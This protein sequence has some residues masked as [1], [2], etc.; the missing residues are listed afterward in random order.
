[1]AEVGTNEAYAKLEPSYLHRNFPTVYTAAVT[2]FLI[3]FA[4]GVP[5]SAL[6]DVL[7]YKVGAPTLL[8]F[9]AQLAVLGMGKAIAD[10]VGGYFADKW[11]NGRRNVMIV[12]TLLVVI[13]SFLIW[14]SF[15][16]LNQSAVD[17]IGAAV[18]KKKQAIPA[19][20]LLPF[21]MIVGGQFLNGFGIGM[22]NGAAMILLQ[23]YGGATKRGL[24]ASLQKFSLYSGKTTATYLGALLGVVT[25]KV[26]FPFLFVGI[27]AV[28]AMILN[29]VM[30]KDS[31]EHILIPAGV[32]RKEPTLADYKPAFTNRSLYSVYFVAFMGKW[33]DSWFQ[34][35]SLLFM[36][37]VLSVY[38]KPEVGAIAAAFGVL[39]SVLNAYSGWFSDFVGRRRIALVGTAMGIVTPLLFLWFLKGPKNVALGIALAAVWG[40]GTGLYYGITEV[41]PGDVAR[42]ASRGAIIGTF[43]FFRDTG[44]VLVP[45]IF[46]VIT[47]PRTVGFSKNFW[48]GNERGRYELT[49]WATSLM[50]VV[51]FAVVWFV[52]RETFEP[53]PTT[54]ATAKP[55]A[56]TRSA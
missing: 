44:N 11:K 54:G 20:D 34:S 23:D 27:L 47:D 40:L 15:S 8:L 13:G 38:T 45:L 41:V 42:L 35:V 56:E 30:I 29:I 55:T 52:M 6:A 19:L 12:G 22:Q 17:A 9:W 21:L 49:L 1:M 7:K 53:R 10:L 36:F 51:T 3:N 26:M 28:I 5:T 24:G 14:L 4:L 18:K 39:W 2:V 31:K 32:E 50:M 33:S 46:A 25:G 43:R 16:D 37:T 48:G